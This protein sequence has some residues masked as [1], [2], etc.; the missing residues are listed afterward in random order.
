MVQIDFAR[1][2]VR[3]QLLIA[4]P[5]GRERALRTL[6]AAVPGDHSPIRAERLGSGRLVSATLLPS[7]FPL[8]G[9]AGELERDP[10]VGAMETEFV[11]VALQGRVLE[12]DTSAIQPDGVLYVVDGSL[13]LWAAERRSAAEASLAG[14]LRLRGL[15]PASVPRVDYSS[16]A[17]PSPPSG[18]PRF[19]DTGAR[20]RE[21]L[22]AFSALAWLV[23]QRLNTEY[24]ECLFSPE[25]AE[26]FSDLTL[27]VDLTRGVTQAVLAPDSRPRRGPG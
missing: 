6:Q 18:A 12:R 16:L 5:E 20:P 8:V 10:R 26:R 4:G 1:R 2:R 13:E 23:L 7:G 3:V 27:E 11:L 19:H 17:Q 9:P 21:L 15:D 14:S 22:R 24:C 25:R